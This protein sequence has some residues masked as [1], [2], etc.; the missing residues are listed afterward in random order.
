MIGSNTRRRG[1][2]NLNR[3][4]EGVQDPPNGGLKLPGMISGFGGGTWNVDGTQATPVGYGTE[5][6]PVEAAKAEAHALPSPSAP[7][8]MVQDGRPVPF[9]SSGPPNINGDAPQFGEQFKNPPSG[10][11]AGWA[12]MVGRVREQK[13][14]F[15]SRPSEPAGEFKFDGMDRIRDA[16]ADN[17]MK[18]KPKPK[19]DWATF[20]LMLSASS[21]NQAALSMLQA[22]SAMERDKQRR[23]WEQE[24]DERKW[25]RELSKPQPFEIYA[26]SFGEPGSPEYRAA[27]NDYVLRGWGGTA[28]QAK[29]GI[30]DHRQGNRIGLEDHRQGNRIELEGV[31]Y[32]NRDRL[33][34]QR[35]EQSDTNNRRST[36]VS[37]D[38]NIRSTNTSREN[39]VRSTN[40]SNTN[41]LRSNATAQRGQDLRSQ[42]RGRRVAGRPVSADEPMARDAQG[43]PLVVRNGKWVVAN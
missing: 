36:G 38:N 10:S 9:N 13:G 5:M 24:D 1:L 17:A 33:Q 19:F 15:A 34:D 14:M 3:M 22:R 39:N 37:R 31:R 4:L 7:K 30:E 40:Q 11:F 41:S 18:P 6:D 16:L 27:L 25:Q 29:T 32:E 42:L 12:P 8:S 26:S 23:A 20:G 21:G 35:L 43:R 28:V 2:P